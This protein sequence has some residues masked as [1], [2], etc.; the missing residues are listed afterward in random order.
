MSVSGT[1]SIEPEK[2]SSYLLNDAHPVGG[3]KSRFF[4]SF[5]FSSGEPFQLESA[6]FRHATENQTIFEAQEEFGLKIVVA[7]SIQTP[8]GRNPCVRSVWLKRY[9]SE[10]Y[11][12]VSAYP[13]KR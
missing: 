9:D 4:K 11:R 13:A 3:P 7:C 1:C 8:D 12:L 6:L 2:I 5:G 10:T